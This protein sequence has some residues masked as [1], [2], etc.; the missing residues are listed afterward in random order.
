VQVLGF[1]LFLLALV[2]F[3]LSVRHAATLF[4]LSVR[5]KRTMLVVGKIPNPLWQDIEEVLLTFPGARGSVIAKRENGDRVYELRGTFSP[6]CAQRLR[7]TLGLYSIDAL[8]RAGQLKKGN[9]GQ[10]LGITWLAWYLEK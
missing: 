6:A 8:R 5:G 4:V 3:L 9:L 7:N 1:L 2:V 10:R